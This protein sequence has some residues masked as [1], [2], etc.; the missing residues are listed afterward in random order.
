MLYGNKEDLQMKFTFNSLFLSVS[1]AL[2]PEV[3]EHKLYNE[4]KIRLSIKQTCV[5]NVVDIIIINI[6]K[7]NNIIIIITNNNIY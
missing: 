5:L 6:N 3:E 2:K 1:L 4:V 7:H